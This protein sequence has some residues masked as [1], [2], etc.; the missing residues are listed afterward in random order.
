[1]TASSSA[2]RDR[3]RQRRSGRRPHGRAR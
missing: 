2:A 1:V 3:R